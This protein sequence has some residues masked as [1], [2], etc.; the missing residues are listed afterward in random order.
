MEEE[1]IPLCDAINSV[2]G[3]K[4]H[5]CCSGHGKKP[6]EI[7]LSS[8]RQRDLY[9]AARAIDR[10]Y[11]GPPNWI[12]EIQDV[13]CSETY[14]N[15]DVTFVLRSGTATGQ[16][17]YDQAQQIAKNILSTLGHPAVMKML[18]GRPPRIPQAEGFCTKCG[19]DIETFEDLTACPFCGTKGVPCSY[20]EQLNIE[21]NRH[22][23]RIL[24][25]WSEWH[26]SDTKDEHQ[27]AQMADTLRSVVGRLKAQ[28]PDRM[29]ADLLVSDELKAIR[30]SGFNVDTNMTEI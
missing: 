22:E 16:E 18:Y 20:E 15:L 10:R 21:I 27:Q 19:K 24:T 6:M 8:R 29:R 3:L 13:D 7:W 9:L 25:I 17:A 14:D 11:G 28:L 30:G 26:V 2:P 1:C 23:L 5:S 4:T 12:L